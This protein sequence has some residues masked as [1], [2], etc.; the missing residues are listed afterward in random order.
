M[1]E[2]PGAFT[3]QHR[4][5]GDQHLVQHAGAQALRRH[6]GTEDGDVLVAGSGGCLGDGRVEAGDEGET[7]N[8]FGGRMVG[9]HELGTVP[10]AAERFALARLALERVVPGERAPADQQRAD[11]WDQLVNSRI[12]PMYSVSH[13]MSPPAPAMKPSTDIA[14]E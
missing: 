4:H 3:E 2:Q 14:A 8:H 9:E 12:G 1:L 11:L 6:V 5:D 13:D 7:G 10:A